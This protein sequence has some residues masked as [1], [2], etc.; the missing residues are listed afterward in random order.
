MTHL[1]SLDLEMNQPSGKIIQIGAAVGCTVK[2]SVLDSFSVLVDPQEE[3][4]PFIVELTGVTPEAIAKDGVD[5]Q[6]AGQRLF[7]FIKPYRSFM[8]PLTW[9]GADSSE[10]R[11]QLGLDSERWPFGRRW[12][13]VKTVHVAMCL[14]SGI[15]PSGGLAKT[16]KKHYGLNFEGDS[17]DARWD[18]VN[19]LRLFFEMQ[20]RYFGGY[21]KKQVRRVDALGT[22]GDE[23]N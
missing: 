23:D 18:A 3:L 17:H 10:L 21:G 1:V 2:K 11:T 16:M 14:S 9:G 20:G 5:M 13:D 15:H 19:T 6:T 4:N 12:V 8:N 22:G 7:E